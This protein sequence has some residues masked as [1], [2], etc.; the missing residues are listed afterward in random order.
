MFDPAIIAMC[1][2]PDL[3]PA[4]IER[5]IA[6]A[7]S[8]DPFRVIV[9]VGNRLV[10][11]PEAK[12]AEKA[13]ATAAH[14]SGKAAVRIG[15]TQ[16]PAD[17]VKKDAPATG[18]DLVDPCHNIRMGTA[19]FARIYRMVLKWYGSERPEAVDD[20]IYAWKTG[21]F[22][23]RSVFS[24]HELQLDAVGAAPAPEED[25]GKRQSGTAENVAEEPD[26]ANAD[27]RIDLSRIA[28]TSAP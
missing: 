17:M 5:F 22:E 10:P 16:F 23:G 13:L 4:I 12:T 18:P 21:F 27:L 25:T 14:Y 8:T 1:A 6:E 3:K 15:V 2:D 28:G 19:L 11:V 9:K 26:P 24:D 20:A 7:G